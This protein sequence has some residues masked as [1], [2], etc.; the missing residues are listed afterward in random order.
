MCRLRSAVLQGRF[1][2]R[3]DGPD[4]GAQSAE[5]V[6]TIED[7]ENER[8]RARVM[9]GEAVGGQVGVAGGRRVEDGPVCRAAVAPAPERVPLEPAE[10]ACFCRKAIG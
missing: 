7:V 8:D 4:G 10:M 1:G 9:V 2:T 6:V 5:I 3:R